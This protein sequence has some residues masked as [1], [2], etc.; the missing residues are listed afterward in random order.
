LI[1]TIRSLEIEVQ[2]YE[3]NNEML[4]REKIYINSQVFQILNHLQ[5]QTKDGSK[6]EEEGRY[7]ESKDDC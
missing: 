5:R 7:H 1:E 4:M 2:S 3:E 6:K